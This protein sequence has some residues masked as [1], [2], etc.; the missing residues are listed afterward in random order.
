MR[1]WA[2]VVATLLLVAGCSEGVGGR[3]SAGPV[4][5]SAPTGHTS[6]APLP[7]TTTTTTGVAPTPP[8]AG[9]PMAGVIAWVEAGQP[10]D[11]RDYHS[12]TREGTV[13]QLQDSDV[14]FTTPSGKT[15]CMTD[16]MFSTGDLACLVKLTNPPPR[17]DAAEGHWIGGWVDFDGTTLTVGSVHGDPGRFI[18]GDGGKL[19]YGQTLKF[20][21]YQ[22]RAD[23]TGLFCVNFAHQ[24]AARISDAGVE[25]FGCLQKVAPPADIGDKYSC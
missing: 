4:T 18:Y 19:A 9:A 23:E 2:P 11:P 24:S 21:D 5:T 12:A 14:A 25:P 3:P 1:A 17:P 20:A 15:S 10:A 16:S 22:C 7:P 13:T 8:A 6:S